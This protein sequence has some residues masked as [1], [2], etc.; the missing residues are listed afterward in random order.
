M[1]T[2]EDPSTDGLID[3]L[4]GADT[5]RLGPRALARLSKLQARLSG[6]TDVAQA[7][8]NAQQVARDTYQSVFLE[9]CED[10]GI[11]VPPGPHGVDIDWHTGEVRFTDQ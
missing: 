8:V 2:T 4:R 7:A 9:Y 6:A 10:Y 11:A 1:A 3:V 5:P